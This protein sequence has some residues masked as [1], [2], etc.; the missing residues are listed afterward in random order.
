MGFFSWLT[1]DTG[2]SITN[3]HSSK[4]VFDVYVLVPKE[5]GGGC[6][7]ETMYCG[8]GI[9]ADED[10]YA[11]CALWN[12]PKKS[13]GMTENELRSLGI[14][15]ADTDKKNARLKYPIKLAEYPIAYEDAPPSKIC[16]DQGL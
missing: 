10:I 6:L 9:F 11:L 14:K 16:P 2:R 3:I 13:A 1:C 7:R 8:Y 5:L 12:E 4:G 15:L